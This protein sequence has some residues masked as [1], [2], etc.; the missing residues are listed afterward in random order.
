MASSGMLRRVAV[1]RTDILEGHHL[2][3]VTANVCSSPNLVTLMMEALNSSET[4]DLTKL[5]SATSQNM[6]FFEIFI[7]QND[8]YWFMISYIPILNVS[9]LVYNFCDNGTNVYL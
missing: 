9:V 3:L 7:V 4:S 2:L 1:V 8:Q 5:H 6:L